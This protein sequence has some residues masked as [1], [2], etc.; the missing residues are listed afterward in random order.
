MRPPT[1]LAALQFALVLAAL[2]LTGACGSPSRGDGIVVLAASSLTD[3]VP[4]VGAR[5]GQQL[6]T[7]FAGS[8]TLVAQVEQGVPADVVVTADA[9]SMDRLRVDRKIDGSPTAVARNRLEIVVRRGNPHHVARLADLERRDVVV[10]LAA[11]S[12]PAG[13]A[14]TEALRRAAVTLRP[15]SLEASVRGV[16]TKVRLGE[17]DAGVVYVTDVRAGGNGVSGVPIPDP[18]NVVTTYQA[19]VL[20]NAGS[21]QAA[22]GFVRALTSDDG[23]RQFLRYGFLAP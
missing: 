8:Q 17:A 23:R 11:P 2:V 21:P 9:A 22:R 19:A 4:A 18:V 7:S 5:S 13:R 1:R 3:V 16:L 14:T 6:T 20:R 15:S 10:V 12:V